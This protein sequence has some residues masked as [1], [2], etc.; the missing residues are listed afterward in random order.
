LQPENESSTL[1]ASTLC[2][3]NLMI[4]SLPSKQLYASLSLAIR[5]L[6]RYGATVA[7]LA[8]NQYVEGS[9]PSSAILLGCSLVV[10]PVS[11]KHASKGSIP[12]SPTYVQIPERSNGV[13]CRPTGTCSYGGSNPSLCTI[14]RLRIACAQVI[15]DDG[16]AKALKRAIMELRALQPRP[17]YDNVAQ[18]VEH[19]AEDRGVGGANPSVGTLIWPPCLTLRTSS[20]QD[21]EAS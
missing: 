7:Q 16:L 15:G 1:S 17:I 20:L 11:Y 21:G 18:V 5:F 8:H 4:K 9:T 14:S 2:G 3:Y 19:A 6:L 13:G 10:K 12:F